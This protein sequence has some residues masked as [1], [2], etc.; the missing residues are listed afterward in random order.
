[1]I[2]KL[3]VVAAFL[4]VT[5][6]AVADVAD[7][8]YIGLGLGSVDYDAQSISDFDDPTGYEL[9]VGKDISRNIAF[10]ISYID[11][12]K[13]DDS[14]SPAQH[15]EGDAFTAGA[16]LKAKLGKVTDVF[17][18][19][20]MHSWDREVSQDGSGVI[21]SDDGI[22]VL[23]GF[24]ATVKVTNNIGVGARYNVYSFDS[25]DVTMLSINAQI[26]F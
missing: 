12:G 17:L 22:D 26:G 8:A 19:L 3:C 6:N 7:T 14:S 18:K 13:A 23:Y 11:F 4:C 2:R 9:L 1:M 20:G 25:D 16:L 24:G 15:L 10:E 21:G 5:C